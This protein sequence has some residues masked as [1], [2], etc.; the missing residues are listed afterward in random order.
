MKCDENDKCMC[1]AINGRDLHPNDCVCDD[2]E[3][4]E[5]FAQEDEDNEWFRQNPGRILFIPGG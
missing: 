4:E 1:C 5:Y 3:I 2:L